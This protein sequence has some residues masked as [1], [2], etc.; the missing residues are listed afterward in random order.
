MSNDS[1]KNQN[2]CDTIAAIATGET[3]CAIGIIRMSGKC[4]VTVADEIFFAKCGTKLKEANSKQMYYGEVRN[5]DNDLI[6][7][8]LCFI[9]RAPNSYTGEDCVEFHCHGNPVLLAEIMR[10]LFTLG[11]RQAHAGEF[12]KRAFLNGR[13]DLSGAEAVIDLIEGESIFAVRDS[14]FRLSGAVFKKLEPIYEKITDIIAHFHAVIDYPDE[15]IEEFV[16]QEYIFALNET[17]EELAALLSYHER[18]RHVREGVPVAIVGRPNTGK[19][20]LLNAILGYERAIVTKTAGTTRDTVE[21]K[22]AYGGILLRFI[23]TAGIRKTSDEI[24]L[25][26]IDRTMAAIEAAQLVMVVM[27]GSE[28]MSDEDSAVLELIAK[29]KPALILINKSDL[30]MRLNQNSAPLLAYEQI[31][32]SARLGAGMDV[33]EQKLNAMFTAAGKAGSTEVIINIRQAEAVSRAKTALDRAADAISSGFTSDAVLSDL[34]DAISAIGE[35]NGKN[36][37]ESV[38]DKIFERFCVGK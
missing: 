22:V 3:L 9:S 2:Y 34:E 35:L 30:P 17:R 38:V 5:K 32:I 29:D 24:E 15:D 11:I 20:S 4:A 18:G 10:M 6:D 19:S 36:V 14:V 23:D 7:L 12:T 13:L 1:V 16:L 27:D 26:G 21:E 28:P 37:S 25:F 33:L 31:T 8:C